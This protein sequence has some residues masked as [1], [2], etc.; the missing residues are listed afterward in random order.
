[1][2]K[3]KNCQYLTNTGGYE[4]PEYSCKIFGDEVPEKYQNKDDDG[5]KCTQK[6]LK[7][8]SDE[9]DKAEQEY[10]ETYCDGIAEWN[11]AYE[12]T[13]MLVEVLREEM[14][15]VD[16][17]YLKEY[18]QKMSDK[19]G[20]LKISNEQKYAIINLFIARILEV[21]SENKRMYSQ[22]IRWNKDTIDWYKLLDLNLEDEL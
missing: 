1:M 8:R 7:K 2:P 6:F 11:G 20:E 10:W 14:P 16:K 15:I 22:P 21:Y 17:E 9:Y 5:C 4:Y 13:K 18:S 19:I 12:D 3:C